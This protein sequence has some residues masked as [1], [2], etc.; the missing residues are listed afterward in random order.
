VLLG[1]FAPGCHRIWRTIRTRGLLTDPAWEHYRVVV[2]NRPSG[3]AERPRL[4]PERRTHYSI[5]RAT[6]SPLPVTVRPELV[7][8]IRGRLL[9]PSRSCPMPGGP[10]S[11]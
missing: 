11:R 10:R 2:L 9:L 1:T 5:C 7:P 3:C 8:P 6:C 4:S